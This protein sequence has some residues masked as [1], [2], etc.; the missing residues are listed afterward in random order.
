MARS[1]SWRRWRSPAARAARRRRARRAR[2]R[3]CRRRSA[4]L[5]RQHPATGV[6]IVARGARAGAD[7]RGHARRRQRVPG[8]A[9]DGAGAQRRR[10]AR[11]RVDGP[12]SRTAR[13]SR[14]SAP[15][16][17]SARRRPRPSTWRPRSRRSGPTSA[18][19]LIDLHLA[20]GDAAVLLGAE[21]RFSVVDAL[22]NTHRLDES[23]FEG[24]VGA[25]QRRAAPARLVG[26]RDVRRRSMRRSV[27]AARRVRRRS[28]TATS[29]STC[30][31]S[32]AVALDAL[33]PASRIVI[34]ANQELATVRNA[35]RH[36]RGAAAALRQGARRG[37]R[38]PL[39]QA[40]R[41]RPEDVERVVG[42]PVRV[43]RCR[44]TT[45]WRWR[46]STTGGPL[47]LDNHN[48]LRRATPSTRLAQRAG[49]ASRRSPPPTDVEEPAA[50][51]GLLTGRRLG[52]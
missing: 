43:T 35:G 51:F 37:R 23:F 20:Y 36:R 5:R 42:S 3:A 24:L 11:D 22:E 47:A 49:R 10:R 26:A 38:E 1:T 28:T 33:E 41:D 34:V 19:L 15:R 14:S 17:A 21:P 8:R 45:G 39:R 18:T 44:A 30:P 52:Q 50:C 4:S 7:A 13:S 40:G 48:K 32:D 46:R 25:D 31:R 16:A 9:A 6:V 2:G 12:A 29:C 27:D